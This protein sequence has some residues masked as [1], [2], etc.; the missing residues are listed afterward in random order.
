MYVNPTGIK[1][2]TKKEKRKRN[3]YSW[4]ESEDYTEI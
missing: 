1:N 2:I 3:N 4:G